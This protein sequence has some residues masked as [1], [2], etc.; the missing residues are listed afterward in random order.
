MRDILP[1]FLTAGLSFHKAVKL[2]D[3]PVGTFALV[4]YLRGPGAY[5]I[6][7]TEDGDEHVFEATPAATADWAHGE[8]SYT[9]RASDGT[10]TFEVES[11]RVPIR[12]DLASAGAGYDGRSHAR[13][14]LD[15]IEAVINK[16]ASLD[17]ERYRINNRELYRTPLAELVKFR[18]QY[19]AEV[20]REENKLRGKSRFGSVKVVARPMGS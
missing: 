17:Q 13:K 20:Q 1:E 5:T 9:V 16:R 14:A 2:S 15:A 10:D 8:Y 12:P 19:R 4:L 6:T 18:A 11:G 7:A 3:Y